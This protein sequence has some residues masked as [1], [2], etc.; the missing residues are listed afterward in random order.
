MK[1][2]ERN[3]S[4]FGMAIE[5][6][7]LDYGF[8]CVC[9]FIKIHKY[10]ASSPVNSKAQQFLSLCCRTQITLTVR[11]KMCLFRVKIPMCLVYCVITCDGL[12]GS[13]ACAWNSPE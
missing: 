7:R 10:R 11:L 6:T 1:L 5:I 3:N 9:V 4:V 13:M 12:G 2:K 8:R